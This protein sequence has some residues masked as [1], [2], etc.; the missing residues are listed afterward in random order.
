MPKAVSQDYYNFIYGQHDQV[1]IV[2]DHSPPDRIE[3]LIRG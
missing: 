1:P 3:T 2:E